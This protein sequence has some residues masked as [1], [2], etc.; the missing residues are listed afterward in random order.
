[1][2]PGTT[3]DSW[4]AATCPDYTEPC[5][6]IAERAIDVTMDGHPGLLVPFT[7]DLQ[8]FAV[9]GDRLYVIASGRPAGTYG[10]LC[11]LSYPFLSL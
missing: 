8:A 5:I 1:M 10:T 4:L 2:A 7:G 3:V 6:G 11:E 9:V